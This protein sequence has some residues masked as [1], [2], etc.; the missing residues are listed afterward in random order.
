MASKTTSESLFEAFCR[1]HGIRFR[2]I[3]VSLESRI[4]SPDYDIFVKRGRKIVVEVKQIDPNPQEK[5]EIAKFTKPGNSAI[6]IKYSPGKRV[7]GKIIDAQGK[8]RRRMRSRYPSLLVLFNNVR[9]FKHTEVWDVLS[10]MYGQPVFPVMPNRQIGPMELGPNR[11]MT[12]GANGTNR[13]ISAVGVLR[14]QKDGNPSLTIYPNVYATIP[15]ERRLLSHIPI[16]Y[17]DL[18]PKQKSVR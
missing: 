3:P 12:G 1:A 17:H 14:I 2:R 4:K 16:Q 8:F 18:D 6:S 9:L 15:L 13:S 5:R 11:T 7:R 10:G